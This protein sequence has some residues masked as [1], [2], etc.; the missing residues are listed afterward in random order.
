MVSR[1][2]IYKEADKNLDTN[3]HQ[4]IE[5]FI[6]KLSLYL[7]LMLPLANEIQSNSSLFLPFKPCYLGVFFSFFLTLDFA[8]V[9]F[10][11]LVFIDT[12][13]CI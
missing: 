6:E 1:E 3:K 13:P 7:Q 8:F 4:L 9:I 12:P 5:C 10:G 2:L 11:K